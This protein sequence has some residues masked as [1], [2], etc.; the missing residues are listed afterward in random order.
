[1][2]KFIIYASDRRKYLVI[3]ENESN[4]KI[5]FS[6]NLPSLKIKSITETNESIFNIVE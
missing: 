5:K 4:A 6:Q 1:M 2:E 3:A